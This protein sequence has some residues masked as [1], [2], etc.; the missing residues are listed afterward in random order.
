MK[1]KVQALQTDSLGL[2]HVLALY[3]EI[4]YLISLFP[5]FLIKIM[6]I[7]VTATS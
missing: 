4:C 6:G 5:N 1:N 2:N 7:I 3:L